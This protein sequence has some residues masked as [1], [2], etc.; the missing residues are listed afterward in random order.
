VEV[1]TSRAIERPDAID[2]RGV[3]K[4]FII[5]TLLPR[6]RRRRFEALRG[7]DLRVG[8]GEIHGIIGRNGSGKST[9]L[10]IL[11]TLVLPTVGVATVGGIDA[12]AAPLQVRRVVGFST[13]EERSLYWRL[14]GRQNMEF[15]A[16]LCDLRS[17]AIRIS[18]VLDSVGLRDSMDRRVSG[19]SQGMARRLALA[20][21]LLHE[22]QILILDEPTRSLDPLGRDV[23]HRLLLDR[24]RER[25]TTILI[26]THDLDE[27]AA[28]CD[29][30]SVMDQGRMTGP[31]P[32][33]DARRLKGELRRGIT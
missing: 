12:V 13:G 7:V 25:G 4:V 22:P 1:S 31:L 32:A 20:R 19:Y 24:R 2:V 6:P 8:R 18:E 15:Y 11:A 21:A 5:T 17:P 16:A 10:R 9:L 26:A 28:I 14:T 3:T 27:A 23:I 29:A 33:D 30:V